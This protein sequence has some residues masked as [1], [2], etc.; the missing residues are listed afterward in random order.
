MIFEI[1]YYIETFHSI[2][3]FKSITIVTF[4]TI[5]KSII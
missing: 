1:I 4:L 5:I 2:I 3:F